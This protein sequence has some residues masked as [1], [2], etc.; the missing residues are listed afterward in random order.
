[1]IEYMCPA[2]HDI[3]GHTIRWSTSQE[4]SLTSYYAQQLII[5]EAM[6]SFH[7]RATAKSL[8]WTDY[9]PHGEEMEWPLNPRCNEANRDGRKL[10]KWDFA[11][12][13]ESSRSFR[14]VFDLVHLDVKQRLQ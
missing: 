6:D 3:N 4:Y 1:M 5:G 13:G 14:V 12:P 10:M 2:E 11:V 7:D 9:V 8:P